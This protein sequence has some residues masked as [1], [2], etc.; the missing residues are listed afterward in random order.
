M[1]IPL[2]WSWA[3]FKPAFG[4]TPCTGIIALLLL[5]AL[6]LLSRRLLRG[7]HIIGCARKLLDCLREPT[8]IRRI[9]APHLLRLPALRT[10]LARRLLSLL[11]GLPLLTRLARLTLLTG[12]ALL[13]LLTLLPLLP[14]L[15]LLTRLALLT[16]LRLLSGLFALQLLHLL[17][18]LFSIATQ[19]FL[20]PPLFKGLLFI[21]LLLREFLLTPG[22]ILQLLQSLVNLFLPLF[23]RVGLLLAR[24]ILILFSIQF[25]VEKVR[26]I[27]ARSAGTS[28]ATFASKCYLNIPERGFR[29]RNQ[30]F[31]T[32]S[33]RARRAHH[34]QP[35]PFSLSEAG[36]IWLAASSM[37]FTNAEN[38]WLA[39]AS[40]RL[41]ARWASED[42]CSF[43]LVCISARNRAFSVE[44]TLF[45]DPPRISFQVAAIIS[46]SRCEI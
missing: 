25:E 26:Q 1:R 43:S 44:L 42:A 4:R 11:T 37:S 27:A 21:L 45:L 10:A 39:P 12:L 29:A 3:S 14:L 8:V 32:L 30:M 15:A 41:F 7:A 35:C 9:A 24:L 17:L 19:H 28:T 16:G 31:A 34:F 6:G 5:T 13:P 18:Q 46:F 22:Q 20:L 36:P 2:N 40:S 33:F 23:R 38:S